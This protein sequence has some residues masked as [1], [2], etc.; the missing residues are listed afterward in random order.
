L[1][2]SLTSQRQLTW[3]I[4]DLASKFNVNNLNDS[5]QG[6]LQEALIHLGLDAGEMT[7]VV[8]SILD[9]LDVDSNPHIDGAET[10]F[11]QTQKSTLPGQGWSHRRSF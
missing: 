11:Y 10:D 5:N 7:P 3:K 8:N 2:A 4:T 9:W 1:N 6:M